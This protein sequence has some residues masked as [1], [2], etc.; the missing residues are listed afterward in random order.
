MTNAQRAHLRPRG[1]A[2]GASMLTVALLAAA[3]GGGSGP[4]GVASISATSS[5]TT[6]PAPAGGTSQA[7][8]YTNGL[9]Y[10]DCMRAHGEPGFP[11]PANPGGFP[12]AAIERL[13]PSSPLF[14]SA[15]SRC[16][17]LLPN[18]GRLTPAEL[19]Q[20]IERG[21]KFAQCMR[22]HGQPN[23]PDPGVSGGQITIN[24]NDLDPNSPQ[25]RAAAQTCG[26]I[27]NA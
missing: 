5:S 24:F 13:D 15:N 8:E 3:C 11:D 14:S 10:A 26:R 19:A 9:K 20:V 2:V 1:A 4:T 23:F 18:D 12:S 21:L 22:A 6:A 16:V 7:A 25:Y 27:I 17:R